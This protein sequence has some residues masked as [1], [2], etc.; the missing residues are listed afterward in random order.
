M[1]T[2][3]WNV[4][5]Y[6]NNITGS[7]PTWDASMRHPIDVSLSDRCFFLFLSLSPPPLVPFFSQINKQLL[8]AHTQAQQREPQA[9]DR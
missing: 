3:V 7:I 9:M 5:P 2:V 8:S 1:Q 4:I 6:T